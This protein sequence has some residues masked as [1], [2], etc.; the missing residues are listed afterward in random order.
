MKKIRNPFRRRDGSSLVH[1]GSSIV[2][3]N[4]K[5]RVVSK[6]AEGGSAFI[7][8][9]KEST[10]GTVYAL[11]QLILADSD[12][13]EMQYVYEKSTLEALKGHPNVIRLYHATVVE[14]E[15]GHRE[16]WMLLEY[17]AVSLVKFLAGS[18]KHRDYGSQRLALPERD[19]LTI[20][21]S[22]SA[23]L[24]AL[25]TLSPSPLAH[26][27][28][29]AENVLLGADGRWKLCD[30][31]SVSSASG[32]PSSAAAAGREQLVIDRT[33]TPNYRPPEMWDVELSQKPIGLAVDMWMLGCL[34]YRVCFG[35]MPFA[36]AA[37][38]QILQGRFSVP[39][40][41][42]SSAAGDVR[43]F[44]ALINR[45]LV[46]E[47]AARITA[48]EART[49]CIER[50]SKLKAMAGGGEPTAALISTSSS[51]TPA[52]GH[53]NDAGSSGVGNG[54]G[55]AEMSAGATSKMKLKLGRMLGARS[56]GNASSSIAATAA[57]TASS[58]S[59]ALMPSSLDGGGEGLAERASHAEGEI[60][61][62]GEDEEVPVTRVDNGESQD[63]HNASPASAPKQRNE[64]ALQ[65]AVATIQKLTT[66]RDAMATRIAQL[67]ALVRR[68]QEAITH[69]KTQA[70]HAPAALETSTSA[71]H[72]G[73]DEMVTSPCTV[74]TG[75]ATGW[76]S[77]A[78]SA[79]VLPPPP[80]AS[81]YLTTE[82]SPTTTTTTTTVTDAVAALH[83]DTDAEKPMPETV[84][85]DDFFGIKKVVNETTTDNK[86]NNNGQMVDNFDDAVV[87]NGGGGARRGS[88]SASS[89]D[90]GF[91]ENINFGISSRN[92]SLIEDSRARPQD[93]ESSLLDDLPPPPPP[94]QRSQESGNS[95]MRDL[96]SLGE[97]SSS[98][99]G[100]MSLIDATDDESV[101]RPLR[102]S[103]NPFCEALTTTPAATDA[104]GPMEMNGMEGTT[105]Q[106]GEMGDYFVHHHHQR[107]GSDQE[108]QELV[109]RSLSH[110]R[111]RSSAD[112]L[113]FGLDGVFDSAASHHGD[114]VSPKKDSSGRP[115]HGRSLSNVADVGLLGDLTAPLD[116]SAALVGFEPESA[117]YDDDDSEHHSS[118]HPEVNW[119]TVSL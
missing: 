5:F 34:L 8:K 72:G 84:S 38:L 12:E 100:S 93:A 37:K 15:D 108:L 103:S 114:A 101:P 69:L 63:A 11:K 41:F 48:A 1:V 115:I 28:I 55:D 17:C 106:Q 83:I 58:S 2:V 10:R 54:H 53:A 105:V 21:A 29:K 46:V 18:E 85:V 31:G 61:G 102:S 62:T 81:G 20:V 60:R 7:F 14:G 50:L 59:E 73:K 76:N 68:Q 52:A 110:N 56:S 51:S 64:M 111:R 97:S 35:A 89:S 45:L 117:P 92:N 33:T 88:S 112:I 70:S 57:M 119:S 109:D 32:V 94:P 27:D 87:M 6:E 79:R 66:E 77:P 25:H 4:V 42:A 16:G 22:V 39:Q 78:S 24:N 96:L 23:A 80:S 47:P 118:D 49:M 99:D 113:G 9:V 43:F 40:Q 86:D 104:G 82:P 95:D 75:W 74:E 44:I 30:F 90:G 3:G 71:A 67:E 107:R 26:R 91:D 116:T 36:D 65:A 98:M 19:T 13:I